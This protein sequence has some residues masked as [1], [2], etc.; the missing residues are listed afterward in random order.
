MRRP[1]VAAMKGRRTFH[2]RPLMSM[3]S[4][5]YQRHGEIHVRGSR[6]SVMLESV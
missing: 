6:L 2:V 4:A 5:T 1:A 3:A